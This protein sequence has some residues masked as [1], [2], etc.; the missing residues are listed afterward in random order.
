MITVKNVKKSVQK[1]SAAE[2]V[3]GQL[4][5]YNYSGEGASVLGVVAYE[6]L[7]R[8]ARMFVPIQIVPG[9][10]ACN[11][12]PFV[13]WSLGIKNFAGSF[14]SADNVSITIKN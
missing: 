9:R 6:S 10:E 12:S 5:Y 11:D 3:V 8:T 4:Y 2:L 1:L 7:N 13:N 14:V